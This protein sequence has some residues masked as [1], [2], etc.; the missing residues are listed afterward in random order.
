MVM[1]IGQQNTSDG[2]R[3]E[4]AR[5]LAIKLLK[6]FFLKLHLQLWSILSSGQ[7]PGIDRYRH[8]K[9]CVPNPLPYISNLALIDS[10][11]HGITG[12]LEV[13]SLSMLLSKPIA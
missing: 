7:L 9:P 10:I 2:K 12:R 3:V 8:P 1:H 11:R 5:S 6:Y 13:S 4:M